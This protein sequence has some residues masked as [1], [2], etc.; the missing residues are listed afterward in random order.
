MQLDERIDPKPAKLSELQRKVDRNTQLWAP[1]RGGKQGNE[2]NY[3]IK[4]ELDQGK[5]TP[6][7]L[8]ENLH[9]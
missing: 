8:T 4:Q 1:K 7:K 9:Q 5:S 6:A 3:R 2:Q